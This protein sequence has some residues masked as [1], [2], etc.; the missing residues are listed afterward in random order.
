V[1]CEL[2]RK[3]RIVKAI[4]KS[5]DDVERASREIQAYFKENQFAAESLEGIVRWW[6]LQQQFERAWATVSDALNRLVAA[7]F[8][9][10][11][12]NAG[13]N[14]VY[15]MNTAFRETN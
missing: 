11:T 3:A 7:G 9:V 6:L 1:A 15:S 12:E 14:T 8:L 4:D 10:R 5:E 2:L 13:G